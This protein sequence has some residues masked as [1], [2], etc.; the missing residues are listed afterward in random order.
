[1]SVGTLA[2]RSDIGNY[3]G[4]MS[5]SKFISQLEALG[6]V[7][8]IQLFVNSYGGSVFAATTIY[9]SLVRHPATVNVVIEGLCASAASFVAM[10]GDTI[11]IAASSFFM[12]HPAQSGVIG[13]SR[14][15]RRQ[16]DVL[17][18]LTDTI[19]GI[20]ASRSG[21]SKAD[22]LAAL[23]DELWLSGSELAATG[24]ATL[25]PNKG[26]VGEPSAMAKAAS[27]VA[28]RSSAGRAMVNRL[29]AGRGKARPIDRSLAAT[30]ASYSN[31]ADTVRQNEI[32]SGRQ[33]NRAAIMAN[34]HSPSQAARY[35]QWS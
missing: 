1:M 16:A 4:S 13:D 30:L 6:D 8:E 23:Q 5:D 17:D 7:D 28:N 11:S 33:A 25:I 32:E 12:A 27:S 21:G 15:M 14:D 19:A 9:Q 31:R 26:P 24:I 20:Y 35:L 2:I 10:A 18:Q 34:S 3:D 29:I 22:W